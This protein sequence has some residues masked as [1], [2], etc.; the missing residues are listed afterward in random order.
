MITVEQVEDAIKQWTEEVYIPQ[1]RIWNKERN[2]K[3]K[4]NPPKI[5]GFYNKPRDFNEEETRKSGREKFFDIYISNGHDV[6]LSI[7][8]AEYVDCYREDGYYL[9]IFKIGDEHFCATTSYDSWSDWDW[10]YASLEKVEPV[11]VEV[12]QWKSVN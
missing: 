2:Q 8:T 9:A 6:E 5:N 12:T 4:D 3:L 1:A 10:D 11:K 7:G